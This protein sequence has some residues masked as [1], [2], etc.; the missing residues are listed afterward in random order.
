MSAGRAWRPRPSIDRW[1]SVD[2]A[3]EDTT[4]LIAWD[5]GHIA[6][7]GLWTDLEDPGNPKWC[8]DYGHGGEV[9]E[10]PPTHWMPLPSPPK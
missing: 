8:E 3:P 2:C 1:R 6:I 9:Q 7:G 10:L 4:V 5:N